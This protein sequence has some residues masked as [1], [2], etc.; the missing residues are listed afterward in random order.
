MLDASFWAGRRVLLTGH[1]GFKGSWLALWLLELGAEVTGLALPPEPVEPPGQPLFD[2]LGLASRLCGRHRLG[3]IRDTEVLAD[4]VR[5]SQPEVVLHLAAQ[6]LVR[7]SYAD[8]LGTW[9]TNV[10]GSLHVL[11]ALRTL[12][13][14][15]AVVMVTTDKVYENREWDYGY[16]EHDRLAGHDPYSASKAAAELA[17]ASWRSSFCGSGAHQTPHL[18]IATARAGN[19]IGGGDWAADRIVPDAMRAL[20]AGEPITVRSPRATRPWQHVLEPLGGYLLLAQTLATAQGLRNPHASAFNLGPSLEANRSVAELVDE[21]LQHWSGS[22]R[23][24]SDPQAPHE[25]SRLH[26]QIDKA[27]HQLGWRPRW[28]FAT[29]VARTV[30][31]YRAVHEGANPLDCCLVDLGAYQDQTTHAR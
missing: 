4:A 20:A 1:T 26:L 19:V 30:G 5:A 15:C 16:R 14:G 25:A 13:H 21:A 28:S 10:Q 12:Q 31:W 9:S 2:G 29:T 7:R 11:E 23:D 27:H 17:I 6:P 22:W 3:D 18:S 24:C 8:P